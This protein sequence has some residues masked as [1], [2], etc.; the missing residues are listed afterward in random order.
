MKY[1]E[2]IVGEEVGTKVKAFLI[3]P[4]HTPIRIG[5][6]VEA[7]MKGSKDMKFRVLYVDGYCSEDGTEMTILRVAL[8]HPLR[9]TTTIREEPV[10]W[11]DDSEDVDE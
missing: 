8:G 4:K 2:V 5:D 10:K 3:A 11:E 7:N 1:Y 9:V 6:T